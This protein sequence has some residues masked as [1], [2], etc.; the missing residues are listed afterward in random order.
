MNFQFRVGKQ[1]IHHHVL[2]I[3]EASLFMVEIGLLVI[4]NAIHGVKAVQ[5][6]PTIV[7]IFLG[8]KRTNLGGSHLPTIFSGQNNNVPAYLPSPKPDVY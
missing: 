8:G 1:A 4:G 2:Y 6:S 5:Y 7:V 3:N